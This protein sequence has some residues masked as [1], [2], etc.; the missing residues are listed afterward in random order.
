MK[1]EVATGDW[2]FCATSVAKTERAKVPL[3]HRAVVDG[4]LVLSHVGEE[5]KDPAPPAGGAGGGEWRV[6]DLPGGGQDAGTTGREGRSEDV[7]G[8]GADPGAAGPV[9]GAGAIKAGEL[10]ALRVDAGEVIRDGA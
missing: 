6:G 4:G 8:V 7:T 2:T 3:R 9:G 1:T 10:G 5:G